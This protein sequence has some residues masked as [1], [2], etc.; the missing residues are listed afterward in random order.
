MALWSGTA[1]AV[2]VSAALAALPAIASAAENKFI[3]IGSAGVTGVYFPAA[4]AICRLVNKGRD[5]HGIRCA[6]EPTGGSVVNLSRIRTGTIDLAL[7]QSDWHYYAYKG[8]AGMRDVGAFDKLRSIFSLHGEPF[9]VV[10]RADAGV[11]QFADLKGK[12]VNIGNRGS[13]QRGTMEVVLDAMGWTTGS[14]GKVLE[15]PSDEQSQALCDNKIDAMVFVSG[16]PSGSVKEATTLCAARLVDVK[17]R[18]IDRLVEANAFYRKTLIPSGVYAGTDR[19]IETFG[20]LATVVAS[21]DVS[22]EIVYQI[23]AS[24]FADLREF[25]KQHPALMYLDADEMKRD[26]LTAPIHAG[27]L[28][29]YR[30]KGWLK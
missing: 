8:E 19:D 30:E 9:T 3:S 11:R 10:A 24:V 29:Y 4:G 2:A 21:S 28:R 14:F 12:R 17:G 23:V 15:L 26:G 22:D 18:A 7:V 16:F 20:T 6:V 5:L 1:V 27:A 25:K 13:G